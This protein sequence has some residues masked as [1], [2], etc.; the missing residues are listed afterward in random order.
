MALRKRGGVAPNTCYCVQWQ[1]LLGVLC[2]A[3][4][5]VLLIMSVPYAPAFMVLPTVASSQMF[6][7]HLIGITWFKEPRSSFGYMGLACA[8]AGVLLISNQGSMAVVPARVSA[9]VEQIA[10]PQF[11]LMNG[12]FLGLAFAMNVKRMCSMQYVFLAAHADGLQFLATRILAGAILRNEDVLRPSCLIV[13][14]FKGICIVGVLH[15]QQLALKE[16]LALVSVA[17][18]LIAALVPCL[19]SATFFGDRLIPSPEMLVA[20]TLT[21]TAIALL[22]A[23]SEVKVDGVLADPFL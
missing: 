12:V 23:A 8:V 21:L 7:A 10:Q 15:F 1:W 13:G 14:C 22:V 18:P 9:V 3:L 4:A 2:D 6:A 11:L 20:L 17:Y 16:N 19:F 5:G